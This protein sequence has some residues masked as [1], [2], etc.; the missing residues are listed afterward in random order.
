MTIQDA[1]NAAHDAENEN[2]LGKYPMA[3][4]TLADH[5]TRQFRDGD[6]PIIDAHNAQDRI[7]SRLM[8]LQEINALANRLWG[9]ANMMPDENIAQLSK[10]IDLSGGIQP[11]ASAEP[12]NSIY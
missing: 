4:R 7:W 1:L 12:A 6:C 3:A 11:K 5:V 8:A 9:W 2:L 10:I